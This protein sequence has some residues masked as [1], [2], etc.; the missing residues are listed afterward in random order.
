M[1]ELHAIDKDGK[2]LKGTD[3]MDK[4]YREAGVFS[5]FSKLYKNSWFKFLTEKNY[6]L[7][8]KIRLKLTGRPDF[9]VL[10]QDY[11]ANKV[12]SK[13]LSGNLESKI[14]SFLEKNS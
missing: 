11:L 8:A 6:I 2:L 13:G 10:N 5:N 9:T 14:L 4:M 3:V 7:W 12:K 1:K